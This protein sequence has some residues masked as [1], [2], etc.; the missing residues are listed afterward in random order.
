LFAASCVVFQLNAHV[1]LATPEGGETYYS[2]ALV[3]VS[4]AET[5]A[6]NTLNWDLLYTLDS[7]SS[8]DT[9]EADIPLEA[10]SYE[11]KVPVTATVNA[12]IRIVQ[13]NVGDDY[14]GTSANFTILVATGLGD[15]QKQI[16]MN[17]YPN[18]MLDY[19]IVEFENSMNVSHTL[20]IYNTQGKKLMSVHD[21][22]S[23]FVRVR[24]KNLAAGLY[25]ISLRDEKEV[26][27]MSKIV[28]E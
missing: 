28:I 16:Q 8:W 11:W 2:G 19:T 10:R 5:Q 24:R 9:L 25:F 1:E 17:V 18:P 14:Q 27:A 26:R 12:K 6:H 3:D 15:P 20:S 4:W 13:D 22:T 21:I 7:G 23:G